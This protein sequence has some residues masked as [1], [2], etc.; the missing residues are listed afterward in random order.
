[1]RT[2][3]ISKRFGGSGGHGLFSD[4]WT[5]E[6]KT[7]RFDFLKFLISEEKAAAPES[8][9]GL[10]KSMKREDG[11]YADA[12]SDMGIYSACRAVCAMKSI[13]LDVDE[14]TVEYIERMKNGDGSFRPEPDRNEGTIESTYWATLALR[15]CGNSVTNDSA[16]YIRGLRQENGSYGTL[17]QTCLALTVLKAAEY[18]LSTEEKYETIKYVVSAFWESELKDITDCYGA[19]V[20]LNLLD[21]APDPMMME[22]VVERMEEADEDSENENFKVSVIKRCIGKYHAGTQPPARAA[23]ESMSDMCWASWAMKLEAYEL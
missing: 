11:S 21:A 6:K 5:E 22:K 15:L 18:G 16:D 14:N 2:Y 13:G 23:P 4:T 7:R 1:M 10:I 17:G 3:S 8:F 9:A 12:E 19:V 20:S